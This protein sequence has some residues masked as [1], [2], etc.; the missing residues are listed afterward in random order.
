LRVLVFGAT[1]MLGHR[2]WRELAPRCE[3]WAAVRR[4]AGDPLLARLFPPDRLIAGL[5][6][7]ACGAPEAAVRQLR[8]NAVVNCIGLVKQHPAAA[9]PVAAITLNALL[10]HRLA[11]ACREVGAR[12]V[13]LSTDC[14]F[15]G[16]RGGYTEDD[17]PDPSDLYGR[18]K[19]LGEPAGEGCLTLR[20]SMVG[21]EL[22]GARGLVEWFLGQRGGRVRGFRRAVFSG[23]A[24]PALARLLRRLLEEHPRLAGTWHVA[25]APISKLDLLIE[26]RRAFGVD[27]EIEPDAGTGGP[28]C[29]RSLDGARFRQATGLATPE[30]RDMVAEL[31][32]DELHYEELRRIHAD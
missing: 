31:A 30:W 9:D 8:P 18:T 10:P 19:L 28:R 32:A 4:G 2:L 17:M 26:L 12:L 5:D 22:A 11:M 21:R 16:A 13:H 6:A 24:T 29:D 3:A 23:L 25:A 7:A 14:V 27:I 20:T 1:G 15:S